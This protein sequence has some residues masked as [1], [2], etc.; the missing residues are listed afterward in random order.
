MRVY[1]NA[2]KWI[3]SNCW[4]ACF[5][6]LG[7]RNLLSVGEDD[8][9]AYRVRVDYEETVENLETSCREYEEGY[10]DYCWFSDTFLMFTPND[11]GRSY[12]VM[13]FA[14][15]RFMHHCISSRIP[16]RGAISVGRFMRTR[17]NRSFIGG[18]FLD[19]FEYAEDQ[20]WIGLLITPTAIEKAK[21]YGLFPTRHDFV[22]SE[23]I[24]MRRFSSSQVLAY[25]FQNG[26]A[27]Y[28]CPILP[29]LRDMKMQ[30]EEKYRSKYEKTEQ[31]IEEHYR[32]IR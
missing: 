19:A 23:T 6:I 25:R 32:W 2:D 20:D 15:K 18:A 24:P 5:D 12:G 1:D 27:N 17:D 22:C 8:L 29:M 30:S 7:F 16:M 28:P 3:I 13:Q 14:A 4:L 10:L 11:S 21:S 26:S 9:K 31:F